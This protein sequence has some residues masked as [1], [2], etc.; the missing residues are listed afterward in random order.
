MLAFEGQLELNAIR[1]SPPDSIPYLVRVAG[2][3]VE[4]EPLRGLFE[5]PTMSWGRAAAYPGRIVVYVSRSRPEGLITVSLSLPDGR[6]AEATFEHVPATPA[7][8]PVATAT[9]APLCISF[10]RRDSPRSVPGSSP[11]IPLPLIPNVFAVTGTDIADIKD[12]RTA[13]EHPGFTWDTRIT[14]DDQELIVY[15]HPSYPSGIHHVALTLPDGRRAEAA[16]EHVATDPLPPLPEGTYVDFPNVVQPLFNQLPLI[17]GLHLYV[18]LDGC[19]SLRAWDPG[20]ECID[21]GG[22]GGTNSGNY[23]P[24]SREVLIR[25]HPSDLASQYGARR[26]TG[27]L[28]HEICHAHQ[29]RMTI[30]AGLGDTTVRLPAP[31]LL[32]AETL[33]GE[34]FF[35]ATG[36]RREGDEFVGA[37]DE[38]EGYRIPDWGSFPVED[39]AEVCA[40]WYMD[41]DKLRETAPRRLNFAQEWLGRWV[42]DAH[43]VD[44][45]VAGTGTR[46]FSGDGGPAT[47]AQLNGPFGVAL[48]NEGNLYIVDK[49]GQRIRKVDSSGI[50]TTVAGTGTAGFSGD[51]GPATSAQLSGPRAVALDGAGNL[52]IAD[53][54]NHRIRKVDT[55]GTITT[56]A[57]TGTRGFSGD[58]GSAT[59]AGLNRPSGVAVDGAG[60]LYLADKNNHR[61]RKVDASGTIT[62]VAGTGDEGFSGDGGPATSALLNRPWA[63]ALDRAGNLYITDIRN[64]RIRKVDTSGTITTVAGTGTAGFSGDGGPATNAQ[65]S[66]P[67]G[68]ALD[69]AGNLY[70]VD[71]R[72]IRIRKVDTGGTITTVAGTGAFGFSGDGGPATSAQ[73]SGPRAV[74]LDGAGNLYIAEFGNRRIRKV[75]TSGTITTV[76]GPRE[77]PD[78]R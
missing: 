40:L 64:I 3:S 9:S 2:H 7:A 47:D 17:D 56:V 6:R 15:M 19:P 21:T 73:L 34:A 72:N 74:A 46:G 28:A 71:N 77:G 43:E 38:P 49:D 20:S 62:T 10:V 45:A 26:A 44:T 48:D 37:E 70:I 63:I 78:P 76:A 23:V 11:S 5:T 32:W 69:G 68:V 30:D 13:F 27:L 58:G 67:M 75:D 29:H 22:A 16:F 54:E 66:S 36:W 25:L 24:E 60:N 4:D 57:G 41:R 8:C 61:I 59:S 12:L 33:E 31:L 18:Q 53:T 39:F 35:E 55:A 50:I 52:Y 65:L 51:G 42:P 1:G 14:S